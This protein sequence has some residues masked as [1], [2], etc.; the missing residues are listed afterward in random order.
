M[1]VWIPGYHLNLFKGCCKIKGHNLFS[2]WTDADQSLLW[3]TSLSFSSVMWKTTS[4]FKK[5]KWPAEFIQSNSYLLSTSSMTG[6]MFRGDA[7][8]N[9]IQSLLWRKLK[10]RRADIERE[11]VIAT[12][13][14]RWQSIPKDLRRLG[15]IP[16][17]FPLLSHLIF[18]TIVL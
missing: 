14:T 1:W 6:A 8:T 13:T 16:R 11:G 15:P 18:M 5:K 17:A 7:E 10:C 9:K 2:Q 12:N 4:W 3:V